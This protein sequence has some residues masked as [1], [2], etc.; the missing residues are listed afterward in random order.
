MPASQII[1]FV[2][3]HETDSCRLIFVIS[4]NLFHYIAYRQKPTINS[5]YEKL[6]RMVCIY[7]EVH[8][9]LISCNSLNNFLG[10]DWLVASS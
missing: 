1:A 2:C 10:C 8:K 4:H 3:V 7:Q 5:F 9:L 6:A